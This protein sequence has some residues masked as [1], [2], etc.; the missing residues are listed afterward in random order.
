L[1][2]SSSFTFYLE[3][4][5]IS[6]ASS[7]SSLFL[8]SRYCV[9]LSPSLNNWSL[10]F[11]C[12][13]SVLFAERSGSST[14][15]RYSSTVQRFFSWWLPVAN[16]ALAFSPSLMKDCMY[17]SY[18][19]LC[20]PCGILI[21]VDLASACSPSLRFWRNSWT[22]PP[23]VSGFVSAPLYWRTFGFSDILTLSTS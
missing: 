8:L 23:P 12:L 17:L 6:V 19:L 15:V 3:E 22:L 10:P 4:V 14:A 11:V 1:L 21:P 2:L 13:E 20:T 16:N 18:S 9:L 5:Y 7:L